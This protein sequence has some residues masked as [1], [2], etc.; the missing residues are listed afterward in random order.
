MGYVGK[1]TRLIEFFRKLAS[2]RPDGVFIDTQINISSST[3]FRKIAYKPHHRLYKP[4]GL[5]LRGGGG[6]EGMR[7]KNEKESPPPKKIKVSRINTDCGY[8]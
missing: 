8:V 7:K 1:S 4:V 5:L 2:C 3:Y 6:K